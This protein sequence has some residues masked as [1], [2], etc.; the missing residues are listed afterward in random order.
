MVYTRSEL[1]DVTPREESIGTSIQKRMMCI[2]FGGALLSVTWVFSV[3]L[4][5]GALDSF[6]WLERSGTEFQRWNVLVLFGVLFQALDHWI[7]YI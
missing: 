2:Q 3:F 5:V 7:I 6:W 4:E 1:Y